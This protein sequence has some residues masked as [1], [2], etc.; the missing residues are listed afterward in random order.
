ML[1]ELGDEFVGLLAKEQ[2]AGKHLVG[3]DDLG[4][5]LGRLGVA[6]VGPE[7]GV[8]LLGAPGRV[9]VRPEIDAVAAGRLPLDQ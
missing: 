3:R 2:R 5:V 8:D 6:L 4:V 9:F 1:G 7:A